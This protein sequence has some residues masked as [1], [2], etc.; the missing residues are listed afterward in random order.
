MLNQREISLTMQRSY[1]KNLPFPSVTLCP[2]YINHV[3]FKVK[4]NL[5]LLEISKLNYKMQFKSFSEAREAQPTIETL[6]LDIKQKMED[7]V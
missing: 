4:S 1:S 2:S 3:G 5:K 6:L 7:K